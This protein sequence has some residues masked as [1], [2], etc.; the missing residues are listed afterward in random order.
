MSHWALRSLNVSE[1]RYIRRYTQDLLLESRQKLQSLQISQLI[2]AIFGAEQNLI[3]INMRRERGKSIVVSLSVLLM[4][5]H[6][7]PSPKASLV[8]W[9]L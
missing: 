2:L 1:R 7:Q 8:A 4:L 9:L 5:L 3:D 6:S